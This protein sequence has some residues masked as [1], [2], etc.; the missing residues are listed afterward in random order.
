MVSGGRTSATRCAVTRPFGVPDTGNGRTEIVTDVV[1]QYRFTVTSEC[2]G[3]GPLHWSTQ[4][5]GRAV[6]T[7]EISTARS[8]PIFA[9]GGKSVSRQALPLQTPGSRPPSGASPLA[10]AG[11]DR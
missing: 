3:T 6:R 9:C 5:Q 10:R 11:R 1:L 7:S 2:V 8:E 4:V